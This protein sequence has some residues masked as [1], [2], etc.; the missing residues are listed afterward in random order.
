[1]KLTNKVLAV[2]PKSKAAIEREVHLLLQDCQPSALDSESE[3][4]VETIF[5]IDLPEMISGLRTGYLD[6]S[7][8]GPNVMGFTDAQEKVSFVHKDLYDAT[9]LVTRRR[10]RATVA[11]EIAHC[12][13][14]LPILNFFK[15]FSAGAGKAD[16]YRVDRKKIKAYEDPEWQ[17]WK[18]AGAILMPQK[19]VQSLLDEGLNEYDLAKI[20]NVNPAFVRARLGALKK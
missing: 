13:Y 9:D 11:H 19:R 14:H 4:D 5:E 17:A 18:Y 10:F 2:A 16:L 8:L 20:F 6:L 15:S 3:V 1:M 7:H 12:I